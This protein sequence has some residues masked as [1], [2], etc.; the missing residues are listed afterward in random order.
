MQFTRRAPRYRVHLSVRYSTAREFVREYAD[1]LSQRGLFIRGAH[2]LEPLQEVKV[3]IELPAFG[4]FE[5]TAEVVHIVP[6]EKAA[7]Y[8]RPAGAGL[9]ITQVPK[10]FDEALNSYLV[11]LGLRKD[12]AVMLSDEPLGILLCA[13]G[14][15]IERVP[16]PHEV[17]AR[18]ESARKKVLGIL[19]PTAELPIYRQ[20]L[21]RIRADNL[22]HPL[23]QTASFD[24]LLGR[25][26][27]LLL[28][29]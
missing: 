1:N 27:R 19:V 8:K 26:D 20:A 28:R 18:V 13:T 29:E 12:R 3:R 24:D 9:A 22:L 4:E 11:R 6:P 16:L 25:L 7:E 17:C 2:T 21:S 5:V 10:G 14:Y 15:R 23:D